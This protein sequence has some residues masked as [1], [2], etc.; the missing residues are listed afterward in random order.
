MTNLLACLVLAV[1]GCAGRAPAPAPLS[2]SQPVAPP[3]ADYELRPINSSGEST[4]SLHTGDELVEIGLAHPLD[5]DRPVKVVRVD[6]RKLVELFS[7]PNR[8]AGVPDSITRFDH[9]LDP[10]PAVEGEARPGEF[11]LV[12]R[13]TEARTVYSA[14]WV[15]TWNSSRDAFD[16]R[17]PTITSSDVGECLVCDHAT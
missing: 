11:K 4:R 16:V 6:D 2:S 3:L 5:Q 10:D 1:I 17:G 13:G 15:F 9:Q 8:I 14:T 7:I 12:V